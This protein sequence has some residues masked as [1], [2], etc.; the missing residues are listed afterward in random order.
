ML[1]EATRKVHHLVN[2][3]LKKNSCN[4][5]NIEISKFHASSLLTEP[6]FQQ[7]SRHDSTHFFLVLYLFFP[8][9]NNINF[10]FE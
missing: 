3:S 7:A 4:N 8:M 5:V 9:I 6:S 2:V 1:A 10:P